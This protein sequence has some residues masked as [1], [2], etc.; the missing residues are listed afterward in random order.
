MAMLERKTRIVQGR[1]LVL[2]LA[3]VPGRAEVVSCKPP[4]MS[5]RIGP[6]IDGVIERKP[7]AELS[8]GHGAPEQASGD[9]VGGAVDA[10]AVRLLGREHTGAIVPWERKPDQIF[11]GE[12][13]AWLG[14][15]SG[16]DHSLD[17]PWSARHGTPY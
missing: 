8:P 4:Q 16:L 14:L 1:K 9:L 12:G 11:S 3:T 2:Q 7:G 10:H 5:L 13:A 15:E 17:P 6:Q